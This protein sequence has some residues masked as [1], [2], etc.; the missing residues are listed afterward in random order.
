LRVARARPGSGACHLREQLDNSIKNTGGHRG[1]KLGL[2]FL[3]FSLLSTKMASDE[4]V[5][6]ASKRGSKT[7]EL[8]AQSRDE[9]TCPLPFTQ[10]P[11]SWRLQRRHEAYAIE[12]EMFHE[13]GQTVFEML[14]RD[15]VGADGGLPTSLRR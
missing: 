12:P 15:V 11:L 6:I 4:H 3:A 8:P 7:T 5:A 1:E 14:L 10:R 2:T 9:S 13:S